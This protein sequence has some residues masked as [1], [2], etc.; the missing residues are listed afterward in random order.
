MEKLEKISNE[1]KKKYKDK[2]KENNAWFF[3]SKNRAEKRELHNADFYIPIKWRPNQQSWARIMF[4]AP[5]PSTGR[6]DDKSKNN[7]LKKFLEILTKYG[8]ARRVNQ[9]INNIH[10]YYEGCFLTDLIKIRLKNPNDKERNDLFNKPEWADYIKRE[11]EIVDPLLI[12]ALGKYAYIKLKGMKKL[13]R[14]IDHIYHYGI[15]GFPNQKK[16]EKKLDQQMKRIK[17]TYNSLC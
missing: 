5:N 14:Q 13:D 10:I 8:F 12:V 15:F 9:I 3:W 1:I 2:P 7:S 17:K 4:V 16:R 6:Y 11:V